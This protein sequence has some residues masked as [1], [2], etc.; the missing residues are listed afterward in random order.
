[1]IIL[2]GLRGRSIDPSKKDGLLTAKV[3]IDATVPV[4]EK[5]RFQRIG[6]PVEIKDKV[7]KRLAMTV[8]SSTPVVR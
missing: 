8:S 7:A 4:A 1:M 3:G 6:V 5:N 2:S